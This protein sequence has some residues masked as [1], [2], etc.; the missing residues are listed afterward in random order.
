M[1]ESILEKKHRILGNAPEGSPAILEAVR[2]G[3][4]T[5]QDASGY[6]RTIAP[7]SGPAKTHADRIAMTMRS[8]LRTVR[9]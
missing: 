3:L 9:P 8:N 2:S 6:R 4:W 5:A 1:S 7:A